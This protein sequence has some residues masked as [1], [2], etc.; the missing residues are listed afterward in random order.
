MESEDKLNILYMFNPCSFYPI[1]I[2]AEIF[3]SGSPKRM[4]TGQVE[5]K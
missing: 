5:I 2:T 3:L 1:I 4:L